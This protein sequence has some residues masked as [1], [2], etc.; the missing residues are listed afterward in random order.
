METKILKSK[1][2]LPVI[3]V[4]FGITG[5]LIKQKVLSSLYSLFLDG[6]FTKG[7]KIICLI[8]KDWQNKDLR[9]YLEE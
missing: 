2:Q 7:S 1:S 3:L 8:R 9:E 4:V 6:K 5:D